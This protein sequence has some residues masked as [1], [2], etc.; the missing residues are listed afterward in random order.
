[1]AKDNHLAVLAAQ[2]GGDVTAALREVRERLS[3]TTHLEVEVD[4]L[5]QIEPVL[6]AGVDTI[7]LDNFGLDD[8]REGVAQVAGRALIEA[9]GGV[10]LS[11]V[12]A[13]AETGVDII[14]VGALTHSVRSLDLGLDVGFA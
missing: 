6:A 10:D 1:M 7:M 8:L 11:T 14:S 12:R 13:I 2:H 4:R 5:D 9:S 3:H